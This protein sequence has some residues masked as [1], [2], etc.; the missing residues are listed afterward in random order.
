MTK[1]H[2]QAL[3]SAIHAANGTPDAFTP[4]Q[5]LRLANFCGEQN[6]RFDRR[7]FLD[8]VGKVAP[9][10][11]AADNARLVAALRAAVPC[12]ARAVNDGAFDRCAAPLAG[13]SALA[14][15]EEALG[16]RVP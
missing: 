3:V 15:C 2:F 9:S 13:A 16:G 6:P 8:A 12:L 5:V 10:P 11:L 1:K 4:D 14:Q 7:R